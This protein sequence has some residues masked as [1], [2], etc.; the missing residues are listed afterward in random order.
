MYLNVE[1][2]LAYYNECTLPI[3]KLS[4]SQFQRALPALQTVTCS[5]ESI[6]STGQGS[7]EMVVVRISTR[8]AFYIHE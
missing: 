3:H 8:S 7:V 2:E 5:H 6:F 1:K 4:A